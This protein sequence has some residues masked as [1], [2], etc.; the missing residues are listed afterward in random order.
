MQKRK[1][2]YN[3]EDGSSCRFTNHIR[4]IINGRHTIISLQSL[5]DS[6]AAKLFPN[7]ILFALILLGTVQFFASNYLVILY[8][9]FHLEICYCYYCHLT[10]ALALS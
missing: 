9:T 2:G 10:N 4:T 6:G 1:I 5:Q 7:L 3:N 8:T